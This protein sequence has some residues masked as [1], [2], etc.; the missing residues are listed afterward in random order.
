MAFE[1]WI[2]DET[3]GLKQLIEAAAEEAYPGSHNRAVKHRYLVLKEMAVKPTRGDLAL[4]AHDAAIWV[5]EKAAGPEPDYQIVQTTTTDS[6]E[7]AEPSPRRPSP[8]SR[9]RSRRQ[10]N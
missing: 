1:E 8:E 4:I 6:P 2:A 5:D 3:Q 10:A 7:T 9:A